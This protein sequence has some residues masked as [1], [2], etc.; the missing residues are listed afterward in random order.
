MTEEV[1]LNYRNMIAGAA[2]AALLCVQSP[3]SGP[4][5]AQRMGGWTGHGMV[6][7]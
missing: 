7:Q 3:M 2:V 5:A 1:S 4:A 6:G